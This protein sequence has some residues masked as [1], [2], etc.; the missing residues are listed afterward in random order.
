M[1]LS[2]VLLLTGRHVVAG[3]EPL[4]PALRRAAKQF[5]QGAL[6]VGPVGRHAAVWA[7]RAATAREQPLKAAERG[8]ECTE[9]DRVASDEPRLQL[10]L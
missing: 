4:A 3:A 7:L 5:L 8:E 6:R 10:S 1:L 9:A 2:L